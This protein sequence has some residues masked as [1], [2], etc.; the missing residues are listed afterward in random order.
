[1]QIL[2]IEDEPAIADFLQ[3]GL[4][5]EGYSVD[6]ALDGIEGEQRAL[7]GASDLVILDVMLPGR[8]GLSVLESIR[9]RYPSLPVIL[10]TARG[11]VE[12]KVAGLDSG[13]TDYLTKPFS[14]D[15]LAARV[16]AHLRR[17][18]QDSS[19]VLEVGDLR[20]DLLGREVTVGGEPV[21]L[22]TREFDLLVYF[23][24]HPGQVLSRE[25]LLNAVWGY[26]YDPQTN[27]AGVYVSYLRKKLDRPGRPSVLETVRGA[28]YKLV[29]PR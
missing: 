24:R 29:A 5:A 2:V 28:G 9:G 11:E 7:S 25:Q 8:D 14:F 22:S 12:D 17:P 1:M 26:T 18:E 21:H 19:T 27:V 23:A 13:A 15:E 4:S 16:R 10:L 3:R 6:C 20:I